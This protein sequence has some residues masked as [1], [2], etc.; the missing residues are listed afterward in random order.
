MCVC[1]NYICV[2]SWVVVYVIVSVCVWWYMGGA[3]LMLFHEY[4]GS[5]EAKGDRSRGTVRDLGK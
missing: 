1:V 3:D 5:D 2:F 4:I